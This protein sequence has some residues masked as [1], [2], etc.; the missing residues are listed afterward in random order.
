MAFIEDFK[1]FA[2]KGNL[3]DMAVGII[4]GG[5]FGTV[6]KSLVDDMFMPIIGL[7]TG[8]VDFSDRFAVLKEGETE[9]ATYFT[10]EKALEDGATVLTYG[11][12]ITALISFLILALVLFIVIK[13]FVAALQ[14][15]EEKPPAEAK[16]SKDIELLTEIRDLLAKDK[17]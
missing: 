4:I 11:N 6:V 8:G 15:E 10:A 2:F 17:S 14:K 1:K 7:M 3:V 13:K 9:G 5:A 12:F 16:V